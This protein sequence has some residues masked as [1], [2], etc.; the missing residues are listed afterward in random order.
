MESTEHIYVKMLGGCSLEFEGSRLDGESLRSKRIW[1]LLEYLLAHRT[2]S[3]AQAELIELLYPNDKSDQPLSALKTLIHRTRVALK[4][5]GYPGQELILQSA[6][7]YTWNPKVPIQLDVE[8]FS[9]LIAQASAQEEDRELRLSLWLRAIDLYRGD[10]LPSS[11]DD[12]WTVSQSAYY[13]YL[14]MNAVVSALEELM[15]RGQH[16]E[17]VSLAQSAISIDQYEERLYYNLILA[18]AESNQLAL[19]KAQYDSMTKLFYNEFGVT[20][21]KNLQALYKRISQTE[22]GVETNLQNIKSQMLEEGE[23]KGAFYCEYEFFKDIYRLEQRSATRSGATVQVCLLCLEGKNGEAL[24]KKA[25]DTAMKQLSESIQEALRSGDIYARYSISQYII[26][27]PSASRENGKM[28]MER[29]LDKFRRKH[30]GSPVEIYY[31]LQDIA[32]DTELK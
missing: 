19:A 24:S 7:G 22:Q 18:L 15:E 10:F 11:A 2:R 14:Y 3:V 26:L 31:S 16:T 23:R 29:I 12:T 1:T 30:P 32:Q 5:L 4:A 6:G 21:S 13:R 20:P 25:R 17:V 8:E 28:V 9:D 27:L